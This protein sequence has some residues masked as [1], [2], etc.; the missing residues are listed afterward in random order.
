MVGIAKRLQRV[1]IK[2]IENLRTKYYKLL[3]GSKYIT[4]ISMGLLIKEV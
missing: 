1:S 3:K 4:D 2:N